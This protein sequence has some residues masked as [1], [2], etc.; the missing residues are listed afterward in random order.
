MTLLGP[1]KLTSIMGYAM[2]GVAVANQVVSDHGIPQTAQEWVSF[3]GLMITG[4]GLRLAKD[5]NVSNAAN[6]VPAKPI[7]VPPANG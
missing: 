7:D 5:G 1:S 2:M 4:I 6:P 3:A